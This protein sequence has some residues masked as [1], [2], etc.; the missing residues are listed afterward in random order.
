M[1]DRE[2][3]RFIGQR[4]RILRKSNQLTI[5]QLSNGCGLSSNAISLVERGEVAPTVSTLCKIA[6]AL[7]ITVATIFDQACPGEDYWPGENQPYEGPYEGYASMGCALG[8]PV[9]QL[10]DIRDS[11]LVQPQRITAEKTLPSILCVCGQLE[12]AQEGQRQRLG[13]GESIL[14]DQT[15]PHVLLNT[16][17]ETGIAL[18]V[19]PASSDQPSQE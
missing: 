15:R 13:P 1:P 2:S 7:G 9:D 19:L 10:T 8:T 3:W 5:K 18:L 12:Y 6:H 4:I 11:E 17:K 16:G 14:V